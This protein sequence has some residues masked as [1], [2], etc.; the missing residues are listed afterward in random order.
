MNRLEGHK[1]I[2]VSWYSYAQYIPPFRLSDIQVTLGPKSFPNQSVG[3][4]DGFSP[5]GRFDLMP[6]LE[7][8]A[9]PTEYDA[10]VV[11]SDASGTNQPLN[12]AAF[13][14]PKVLF[15]G[16]T[17][18]LDAPI[19]K[20]ISYAKECAFDF[21][22]CGFNRQHLHWFIEAGFQNVAWLPGLVPNLSRPFLKNRRQEVCFF[23]QSG[24]YHPR[25]NHLLTE[26]DRLKAFPLVILQGQP[27]M[28]ADRYASSA[29][30]LNCSLNGDLNLRVFE[31]LAAGG[32]LL[33]DRLSPHAGLELLL[34]EGKDYIG[35]DSVEE[36]IE[37]SRFLLKHEDI[38][39][40]IS[41]AGY[42]LFNSQ[43]RPEQRARQLLDWVFHGRLDPRF[44]V[45]DF[46][47]PR[48]GDR[49][50]LTDRIQLYE[51]LQE[52]HRSKLSPTVLFTDDVPDIHVLDALDLRHLRMTLA[53]DDQNGIPSK[54]AEISQRCRT[55]RHRDLPNTVWD[56]VVT[57]DGKMPRELRPLQ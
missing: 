35:Y 45:T 57:R 11:A 33:T 2:L 4:L 42:E 30:S 49:P 19:R 18:H 44:R 40:A 17:H 13:D 36:C 12:L 25:R 20:L 39:L 28:S 6:V 43:M 41:R 31:I 26:I 48:I 55:I 15:V 38:A 32:C 7:S 47:R 9:L 29:V 51:R 1:R 8:L 24:K 52:L 23:G 10:V 5:P 56:C 46:P 27:E 53:Y 3:P 34:T 22:L 54:P 14:C 21:I 16:D 37:Q 50:T